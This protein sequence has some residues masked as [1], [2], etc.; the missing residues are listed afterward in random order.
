MVNSRR[1][2]QRPQNPCFSKF[3]GKKFIYLV[4]V[5]TQ[6]YQSHRYAAENS[7]SRIQNGIQFLGYFQ[8]NGAS[9]KA[10][11]CWLVWD[12]GF[13][14]TDLQVNILGEVLVLFEFFSTQVSDCLGRPFERDHR[15]RRNRTQKSSSQFQSNRRTH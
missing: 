12:T 14:K 8:W 4:S 11:H 1:R 10:I 9:R 7:A 15:S 13:Q 3:Y 2:I 5:Y 6:Q